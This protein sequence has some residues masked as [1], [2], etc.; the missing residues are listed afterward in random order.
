VGSL[1]RFACKTQMDD[2]RAF[3]QLNSVKYL[4]LRAL[5]EPR[6]NSLRLVVEEA[7]VN[8]AGLVRPMHELPELAELFRDGSPIESIEGCRAFELYRNRYAAYLITEELVGSCGKYDDEIYRGSL[9][10]IY[11]K[12]HFL[13][14][15]ARDTGGHTDTV[16]HYKIICLN[17][18]IDVAAYVPPQVRLLAEPASSIRTQ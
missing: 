7:V 1:V 4:Y 12:S 15:L 18:M 6:D 10:R 8:H 13:E 16:Q 14:H 5:S 9:F 3:E 17:H 2:D 11:E